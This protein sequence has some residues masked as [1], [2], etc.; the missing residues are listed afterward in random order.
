MITNPFETRSDSF[1]FVDDVLV[2]HNKADYAYNGGPAWNQTTMLNRKEFIEFL[3]HYNSW[4][5]KKSGDRALFKNKTLSACF[6]IR[7][8]IKYS[9]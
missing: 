2:M 3:G 5:N 7:A 8:Y 6:Q 9:F 1:Y 4:H